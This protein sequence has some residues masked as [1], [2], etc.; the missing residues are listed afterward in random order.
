MTTRLFLLLVFL[1]GSIRAQSLCDTEPECDSGD[2]CVISECRFA[3]E[4][5][6]CRPRADDCD[7]PELCTGRSSVCPEDDE[8][9]AETPVVWDWVGS[10]GQLKVWIPVCDENDAAQQWIKV[11]F[12]SLQEVSPN[13]NKKGGLPS[14]NNL[15]SQVFE[16]RVL[17]AEEIEDEFDYSTNPRDIAQIRSDITVGG[18]DLSFTITVMYF[19]EDATV[20]WEDNSY[21]IPANSVKF[22]IGLNGVWPWEADDNELVLYMDILWPSGQ[23]ASVVEGDQSVDVDI[24]SESLAASLS[25]PTGELSPLIVDDEFQEVS[26]SATVQGSHVQVEL[27]IPHFTDSVTYDPYVRFSSASGLMANLALLSLLFAY[28]MQ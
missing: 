2:C 18:S 8:A 22:N 19:D 24:S 14:L 20:S 1:C 13:G 11:K 23:T 7:V 16:T 10:S 5:I 3:D 25:F 17:T 12:D 21:N 28:L 6:E 15:A 9:Q 27:R 26:V 4:T